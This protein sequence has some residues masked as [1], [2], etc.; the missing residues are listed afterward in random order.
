VKHVKD[1]ARSSSTSQL[2][3]AYLQP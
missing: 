2:L 3:R 1:K